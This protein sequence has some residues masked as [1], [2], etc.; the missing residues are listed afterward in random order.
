MFCRKEKEQLAELRAMNQQADQQFRQ[1][2]EKLMT[3]N[4]V[5]RQEVA[6]KDEHIRLSRVLYGHLSSFGDSSVEIQQSMAKLAMAMKGEKAYAIKAAAESDANSTAIERIAANMRE[7]SQRTHET[8]KNVDSLNERASQIGG[9][10]NLIKEI[11]DQTNLLA[12]NAAIEAARAGEQG[13]GF[14][15]VADEVRKLAERTTK[16]TT[17]ISSL[18]KVIQTETAQAKAQIELN[19]QQAA[20]FMNDVSEAAGNM[21]A[22]LKLTNNMKSTIA[23]SA[24]SSFAEVAKV[25]HLIYKFEIYKVFLGLSTRQPSEFA[26]HTACRLGKWYY[27]GEGVQCFSKLAGYKEIE[28]PHKSFHSQGMVA[29]ECFYTGDHAKGLAM[30]SEMEKSSHEVLHGLSRLAASGAE[31]SELLCANSGEHCA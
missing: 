12:L 8:A 6:E 16:A 3:E 30:I 15:V 18:V 4:A 29:V 25:D 10:V 13:R 26:A 7:M 11:A 21:Q 19:P 17:E 22:L 1:E 2:I 27:E 28:S 23:A 9:I 14:A 31:N 20:S 24:L 5:L